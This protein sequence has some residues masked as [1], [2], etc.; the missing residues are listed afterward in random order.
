M[1]RPNQRHSPRRMRGA[2]ALT[3]SRMAER[4]FARTSSQG[5]WS[6]SGNTT[7]FAPGMR[8]ASTSVMRTESRGCVTSLVQ[9]ASHLTLFFNLARGHGHASTCTGYLARLT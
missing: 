9:R 8:A 3:T 1:L 7:S 5:K 6:Q 2:V 4:R